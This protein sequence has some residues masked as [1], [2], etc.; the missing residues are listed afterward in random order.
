M[1]STICKIFLM[2]IIIYAGIEALIQRKRRN[3]IDHKKRLEELVLSFVAQ[4]T[5]M[6]YS[7]SEEL[8]KMKIDNTDKEVELYYWGNIQKERGK[9]EIQELNKFKP[10]MVK[11]FFLGENSYD[12]NGIWRADLRPI[13][14]QVITAKLK[15]DDKS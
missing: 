5:I 9:R 4:Q 14:F 6:S 2:G 1:I 12:V 13:Y 3:M 7:R 10:E 15:K 11:K 8:K